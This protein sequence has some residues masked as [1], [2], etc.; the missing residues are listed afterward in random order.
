MF[1]AADKEFISTWM[2][3]WATLSLAS[4]LVATLTF[5][6]EPSRFD[7]PERPVI[8]IAVCYA[9]YSSAFLVR[10]IAGAELVSCDRSRGGASD[11]LSLS[12]EIERYVIREGLESVWCLVV[13]LILYYFGTA[14]VVWWALLSITWYLA[15]ARKWSREATRSYAGY[16][17]LVGWSVPAVQTI[18]VLA[19]R[20]VD[21]DE[22][23][24][25]CYVGNQ[26]AVALAGFVLAPY[27]V[28]LVLGVIFIGLVFLSLFGVRHDL[29]HADHRPAAVNTLHGHQQVAMATAKSSSSDVHKL[30]K[31]MARIGVFSVVYVA[32]LGCHLAAL[33]YQQVRVKE[34]IEAAM[35]TPCT[36]VTSGLTDVNHVRQVKHS[37]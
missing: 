11:V 31:L 37:S 30:E 18:V 20:R 33:F 6:I 16:F 28:Y 2:T 22:M 32:A 25:L 13:F 17:H 7:Y 35:K 9:F 21:G 4:C 19:I 34:S 12:T 8:F 23:T 29:K 27:A 26:D 24:G 15:S 1:R 36:V 14:G 10:T 5:L 3:V